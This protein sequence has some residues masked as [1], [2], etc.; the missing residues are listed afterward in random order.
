MTTPIVRCGALACFALGAAACSG[1]G[2]GGG[3]SNVQVFELENLTVRDGALWQVNREMRFTFTQP[4]DF[5]SV[6]F[7]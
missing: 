6:S 2:G 3:T 7:T 4:I 1:S 5:G